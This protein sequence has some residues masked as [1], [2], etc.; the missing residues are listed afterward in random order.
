MVVESGVV[1]IRRI[2]QCIA[3]P[4]I[5]DPHYGRQVG[6][7]EVVR[8]LTLVNIANETSGVLKLAS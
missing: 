7:Q 4:L 1:L 5:Q 3:K 2:S 8:T 6:R